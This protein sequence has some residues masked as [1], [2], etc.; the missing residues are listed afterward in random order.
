M[1]KQLELSIS[2]IIFLD[3]QLTGNKTSCEILN[4]KPKEN[5][6]LI[7]EKLKIKA[8]YWIG[9]LVENAQLE[10]KR[11]AIFRGDLIKKLGTK[12]GERYAIEPLINGEQNPVLEDFKKQMN[13]YLSTKI[14]FKYIPINI[15]LLED[16]ET[17]K[18]Y[19]LA[20]KFFESKE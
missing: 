16:F 3:I 13:E 2:E 17:E 1:E 5:E 14:N 15:D 18:N 20:F 12:D 6:G 11:A 4:I 8:K 9:R 10:V 7:N 19:M